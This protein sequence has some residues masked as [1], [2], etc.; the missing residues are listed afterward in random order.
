MENRL[1]ELRRRRLLT[2]KELAA[3]L[4]VEYQTVQRWEN[5]T[6]RPRPAQQRALCA[7][8]GITPDELLAAL[9]DL[10]GGAGGKGEAAA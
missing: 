7:F 3:G 1:R 6:R 5:G 8:F 9:D 2:Q 4:G 10:T